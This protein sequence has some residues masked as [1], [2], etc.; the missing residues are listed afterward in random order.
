MNDFTHSVATALGLIGSLDA[1]LVGIVWLSLRVSL[2][3]SLIALLIGAPLGVG[4]AI[5]RFRGR[6]VLVVLA[7]ALLGL[8]PV[9]AGLEIYLLLSRSGPLGFAGLLFTP[10]AMIIAQVILTTPIVVALVHRPASLLWAEYADLARSDGL[11]HLR[12]MMLLF[13]LGRA[14]LL[15]AFL[16]AFGRAIAEVGAI[17]I[18]GGNIRGYT[19]TMTTAIALETSKG[20][21]SLALGLGLVLVLLSITVSTAA[22][23]LLGRIGEK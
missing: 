11:S 18:V 1:E 2:T 8:P 20:E 19:R 12:S 9:V 10:T 6:Q 15:T 13:S 23:L 22:F 7:N 4:L 3:A 5:S 17:L 21:L 14:S 16:A